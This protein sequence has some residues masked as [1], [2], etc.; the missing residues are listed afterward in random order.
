VI[1]RQKLET[2]LARRFP[3]SRID[4]IAAAANAIMGLDDEWEEIAGGLLPPD[5]LA[6]EVRVFRRR[7]DERRLP[8][9]RH[10]GRYGGRPG[11]RRCGT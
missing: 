4:Q 7:A 3:G 2:L 8:E 9:I 1:D 6:L 11:P 5:E 10:L